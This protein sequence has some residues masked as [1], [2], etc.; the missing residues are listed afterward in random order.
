MYDLMKNKFI[1]AVTWRKRQ[2][3][4]VRGYEQWLVINNIRGHCFKT[5][6]ISLIVNLFCATCKHI[7]NKVS[8]S[9]PDGLFSEGMFD[10]G[11]F[12]L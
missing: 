8:A 10:G 6:A 7:N 2:Y 5:E 1:L 9:L 12:F 4:Q 11:M 3:I